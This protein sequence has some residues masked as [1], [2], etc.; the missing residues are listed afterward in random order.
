M[1]DAMNGLVKL[2]LELTK[3]ERNLLLVGYKIVAISKRKSLNSIACIEVM[4]E[5]EGNDNHMKMTI[6]FHHMVEAELNKLCYNVI[7]TIDTHLLPYS[8]D[9]E[10][11]VFY[12][13]M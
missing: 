5:E 6:K 9:V 11:K 1:M 8:S 10:G 2:D 7:D 3:E 4:E 13:Q 12:Y